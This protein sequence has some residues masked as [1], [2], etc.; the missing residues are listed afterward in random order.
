MVNVVKKCPPSCY[1][2]AVIC[3][4]SGFLSPCNFNRKRIISHV[5]TALV[6]RLP[7]QCEIPRMFYLFSP[8]F[9]K[10]FAI[11]NQIC[12]LLDYGPETE[13]LNCMGWNSW[14]DITPKI[15]LET[16]SKVSQSNPKLNNSWW[17]KYIDWCP[18]EFQKLKNS[19]NVALLAQIHHGIWRIFSLDK[20][21]RSGNS[22]LCT[23]R[24][25]WQ[26][27]RVVEQ[28]LHYVEEETASFHAY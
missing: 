27:S 5:T 19:W 6:R 13:L 10:A 12:C 8:K 28:Q 17:I 9:C 24:Y 22:P 14:K 15:N 16:D 21:T 18:K 25:L 4:K 2:R 23:V 20:I 7:T 3:D 11:S 26:T 1:A